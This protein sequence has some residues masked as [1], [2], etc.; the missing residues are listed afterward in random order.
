[1]SLSCSKKYSITVGD[2]QFWYWTLDQTSRPWQDSIHCL[3]L[4]VLGA[5]YSPVS[6]SGIISSGLK[7][8]PDGHLE[9]GIGNPSFAIPYSGT[10]VSLAF[11]VNFSSYSG[12]HDFSVY[13]E[14][15][16]SK[17]DRF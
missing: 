13:I 12:T 3:T 16:N 4:D 14:F 15:A 6:S 11:W 9:G 17:H 7:F 10:G 2:E 8:V 5:N 1:M